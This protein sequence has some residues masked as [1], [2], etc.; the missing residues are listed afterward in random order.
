MDQTLRVFARR[1][2]QE[3][4]RAGMRQT[5]LAHEVSDRLGVTL[6]PSALTR[7]EKGERGVR[8]EEAVCI[9][10][11]LGLPLMA[12]LTSEDDSLELEI[13]ELQRAYVDEQ[14]RAIHA[15]RDGEKA[16]AE[17]ARIGRKLTELE[18]RR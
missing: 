16:R 7:I 18:S 12:L 6:D 5:T 14:Q 2:R 13:E 15:E 4:E 3:R 10:E 17:M 11:V 9:A 8:L 1:L